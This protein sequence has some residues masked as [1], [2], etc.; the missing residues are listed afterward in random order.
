[1][2]YDVLV[3]PSAERE[4]EKTPARE[5]SRVLTKIEALATQS[6]PLGVQKLRGSK[7]RFRIWQ[8]R[9]RILYRIDDREKRVFVYAVGDRKDVYR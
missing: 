3:L 9:Y 1:M 8:G 6:R 4:L 2:S 5:L 7:D